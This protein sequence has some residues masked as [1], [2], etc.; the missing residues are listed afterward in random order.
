MPHLMGLGII[1]E[2]VA[3]VASLWTETNPFALIGSV[4][5]GV[6][7]AVMAAMRMARLS[8]GHDEQFEPAFRAEPIRR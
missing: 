6:L 8:T 2:G 3:A 5:I 7:S 1:L 4:S